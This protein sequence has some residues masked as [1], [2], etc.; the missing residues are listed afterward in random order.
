TR[1]YDRTGQHLLT[2]FGSSD[3]PRHYLPLSAQNP[4]H[5]PGFLAQAT[6]A[7][8]QPD[9]WTSPGYTIS[10]WQDA[11]LHPTIAQKLVSDLLLYDEPPSLRRALRE[12]I[13]AAQITSRYGR[14]QILEWY[15]NDLDYGHLAFGADAAAQLYFG[16][17]VT[18]LSPSESAMLAA[19]G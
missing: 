8:A 1:V 19:T 17:S 12:R 13:L 10:G 18:E 6:V 3:S 4:Q 5:L 11:D 9:F 7:V 16:K 15:L 2:V 14:S